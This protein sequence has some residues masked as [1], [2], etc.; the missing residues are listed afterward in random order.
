MSS[1]EKKPRL[2]TVNPVL[3]DKDIIKRFREAYTSRLSIDEEGLLKNIEI[4]K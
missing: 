1:T 3:S 4:R 2:V